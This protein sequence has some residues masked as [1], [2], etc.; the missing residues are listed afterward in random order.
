MVHIQENGEDNL[1]VREDKKMTAGSDRIGSD[2]IGS[3]RIGSDRIGSD[4]IGL[5]QIGS[6]TYTFDQYPGFRN[7]G[8]NIYLPKIQKSSSQFTCSHRGLRT[9]KVTPVVIDM[10]GVLKAIT[11]ESVTSSPLPLHLGCL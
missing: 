1:P 8:D 7:F 6:D 2:R 10:T 4:R 5:D 9:L 11:S 3:D